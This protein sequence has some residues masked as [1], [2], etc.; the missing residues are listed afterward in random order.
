[1]AKRWEIEVVATPPAL[2][3]AY[4]GGPESPQFTLVRRWRDGWLAGMYLAGAMLSVLGCV[5]LASSA[6]GGDFVVLAYVGALAVVL[7]YIGACY[8]VDRTRVIAANGVLSIRHGPLPWFGARDV[9]ADEI[10]HVGVRESSQVGL[11][12]DVHAV[13]RNGSTMVLLSDL[14]EV[15]HAGDLADTLAKHLGVRRP[16]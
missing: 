13:M 11:G 5:E 7:A 6:R 10:V 14:P 16:S 12:L 1:M 2:P 4:R 15:E 9:A 8:V 3:A